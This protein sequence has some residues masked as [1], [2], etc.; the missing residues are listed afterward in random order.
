M[1][2]IT[3]APCRALCREFGAGLVST[4]M[5]A[6]EAVVR[7]TDAAL[8]PARFPRAGGPGCG[9]ARRLRPR[10]HGRRGGGLRGARGR[11]RRRQPRL[12]RLQGG[13]P[14]E[15]RRAR[16]R[17]R[18]QLHAV[19][20]AMVAAVAVPVTVKMRLGWDSSSINA[21]ELARALAGRRRRRGHRPRPDPL[22]E[23]RGNRRLGARS[24]GSRRR[25]TSRSSAAVTSRTSTRSRGG[26]SS[27]MVDG[28]VIARG[29]LGNFWLVRQA[30]HRLATGN[31]APRPRF[32]RAHR[33]G[34]TP[35]R[36]AL[37]VPRRDPCAAHRPQVRGL[38]DSRMCRCRAASSR[39]ADDGHARA[40]RRAARPC[41]R[42][43]SASRKGWFQ[44]VFISG[45]G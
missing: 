9:A 8:A 25:S 32:R 10:G 40:A 42:R 24:P 31:A 44:P 41:A 21:P 23:V 20:A 37:C 13:Q 1:V 3:D 2:G 45:E 30:V 12:P 35:P 39:G 22:P 28:V 4:E 17:R 34:T 11:A 15:R 29:M 16:P 27:G 7:S 6:A 43:R 38:D 33:A 26:S 18:T 14:G 5:V 19:V 36:H